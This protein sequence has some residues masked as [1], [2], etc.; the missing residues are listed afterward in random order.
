M[1]LKFTHSVDGHFIFS[2]LILGSNINL[3]CQAVTVLREA[4]V[5]VCVNG[6][7][8]N[9]NLLIK[10]LP[11][12]DTERYSKNKN[13]TK[14]LKFSKEVQVYMDIADPVDK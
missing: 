2:F 10:V 13:F 11:T 4:E 8:K 1:L 3:L 14:M 5:I 9:Y 12:G 6:R 7:E